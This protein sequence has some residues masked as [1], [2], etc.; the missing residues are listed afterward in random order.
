MAGV[1]ESC[2]R[3]EAIELESKGRRKWTIWK[4]YGWKR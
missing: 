4:Q 3:Q 2:R 1:D